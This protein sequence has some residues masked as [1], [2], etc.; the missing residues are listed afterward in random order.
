M[1][2]GNTPV[3]CQICISALSF[4]RGPKPRLWFHDKNSQYGLLPTRHYWIPICPP[5]NSV[6]SFSSVSLPLEG[7]P[8]I[9]E[10][11]CAAFRGFSVAEGLSDYLVCHSTRSG[12]KYRLYLMN[13]HEF[14]QIKVC[15]SGT[16]CMWSVF[17]NFR[18]KWSL[19]NKYTITFYGSLFRMLN[20]NIWKPL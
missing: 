14:I 8:M 12:C 6:V 16:S 20:Q 11:F 4:Y 5:V 18:L 1:Q 9:V 19:I 17:F 3:L 13:D 10:C 15:H 7:C 2:V